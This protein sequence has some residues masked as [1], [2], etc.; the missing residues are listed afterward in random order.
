[1][2]RQQTIGASKAGKVRSGHAKVREHILRHYSPGDLIPSEPVLVKEIGCSGYAAHRALGEL[3]QL[4]VARREVGRGTFMT[5]KL[6]GGNGV[7]SRTS[8]RTIALI[9]GGFTSGLSLQVLQGAEQYF[10][11]KGFRLALR[12]TNYDNAYETSD[13]TKLDAD[14]FAGVILFPNQTPEVVEQLRR[15]ARNGFPFVLVDSHP[16]DLDCAWIETDHEAAARDA[17]AHLIGL[18]HRRIAHITLDRKDWGLRDA[19]PLRE[20]G[21]RRAMAEAGLAVPPDY[22][23]APALSLAD[24]SKS[25]FG[26]YAQGYAAMHLL[27]RQAPPPTAVFLTNDLLATGVMDALRHERLSVPRD[28]SLIA[29]GDDPLELPVP[30]TIMKQPGVAIGQAAAAMIES[31]VLAGQRQTGHQWLK[32]KLVERGS[33]AS[34]A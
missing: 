3:V 30:L 27:L 14:M 34:C 1:M 4:G 24:D 19:L 26:V 8:S 25:V 10:R 21:Y 9:S 15:L 29:V 6:D 33:T 13:L 20:A 31:M 17:V 11:G 18:G 7:A 23:S 12:N 16:G 22:V 2:A 5:A 28:I 32:A